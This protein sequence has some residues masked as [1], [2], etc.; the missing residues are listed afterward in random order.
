M[1]DPLAYALDIET[2][3]APTA[4]TPSTMPAIFAMRRT[5]ERETTYTVLR[6]THREFVENLASGSDQMS[7]GGSPKNR[8]YESSV[9]SYQ[10]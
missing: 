10:S 5:L 9:R 2:S 1:F 8:R 7:D 3:D 4:A 6:S